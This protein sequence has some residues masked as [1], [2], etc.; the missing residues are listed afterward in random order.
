MDHFFVEIGT[1]FSEGSGVNG[2]FSFCFHRNQGGCFMFPGAKTYVSL[3]R[4]VC[5][6]HGK[7]MFSLR[8]T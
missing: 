5:F 2:L 1:H 3:T 8:E 6:R 7:R 4:N